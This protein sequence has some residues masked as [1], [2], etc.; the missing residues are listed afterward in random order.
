MGII[1]RTYG[2]DNNVTINEVL[3]SSDSHVIEPAGLWQRTCRNNSRTGRPPSAVSGPATRRACPGEK[4]RVGEMAADGVSAEV[5]YPTHGLRA[6][7]LDDPE[8]ERDCARVYNDWIIDYCRAAPDRLIGLAMLR[9]YDV[10]TGS[11]RWSAAARRACAAPH[12]AGAAAGA[13]VLPRTTTSGS[14]TPRRT[15]TCRSTCTS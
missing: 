14:G 15:W 8:L 5:L 10:E 9:M 3:I 11:T 2:K 4:K 6:L 7:S 1:E 12:L 13:G